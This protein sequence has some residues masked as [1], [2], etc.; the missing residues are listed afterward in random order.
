VALVE[1]ADARDREARGDGGPTGRSPGLRRRGAA[2]RRSHGGWAIA[3]AES[4]CRA[5]PGRPPTRMGGRL[6]VAT[7]PGFLPSEYRRGSR[8]PRQRQQKGRAHQRI[9]IAYQSPSSAGRP[10]D[11]LLRP[12]SKTGKIDGRRGRRDLPMNCPEIRWFV[13]R[14]SSSRNATCTIPQG[15]YP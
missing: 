1:A 12:A 5:T 3:S 15:E 8:Y 6:I 7:R 14:S 13:E 11:T 2:S 10:A 9:T 4:S